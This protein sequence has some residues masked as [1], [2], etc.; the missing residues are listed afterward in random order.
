MKKILT[1]TLL[2][3]TVLFLAFTK[4][5]TETYKV[6]TEKSSIQWIGRKITGEHNGTVKISDGELSANGNSVKAGKFT[7]DMTSIVCNDAAN[8]TRHLKSEDFFGVEK[9]PTSVFTITKVT[10]AGADRVNVTGT[11]TIKGIT[12]AIT[13]PATVKKEGDV[14]V[15]V[16]KGIKVDRTKYDIKYR[17]KSFFGDIGDKAIDDE[18]ELSVNLVAKK[19]SGV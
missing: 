8:L 3:S 7:M 2:A 19:Q 17:S 6:D 12:E 16:A 15:A 9:F 10:A 18:F 14:I 4:P 1:S 5:K 13:F 11:L